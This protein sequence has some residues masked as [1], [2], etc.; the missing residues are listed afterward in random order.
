MT[1]NGGGKSYL[2]LEP[3]GLG[4]WLVLPIAG[5][6]VTGYSDLQELKSGGVILFDR[7]FWAAFF[8]QDSTFYTSIWMPVILFGIVAQVVLLVAKVSALIGIFRKKKY[9]P[10]LMISICGLGVIL[11]VIDLV[12]GRYF[13]SLIDPLAYEGF[14][15]ESIKKLVTSVT[16]AAIWIPYFIKSERVNNTFI[17]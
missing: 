10:F 1:G 3:N 15:P 12:L 16:V 17:R 4:G 8:Q 2:P 6:F 9:V 13:F 5:L 14:L 11:A 7:D